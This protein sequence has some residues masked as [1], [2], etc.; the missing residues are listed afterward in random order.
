MKGCGRQINLPFDSEHPEMGLSPMTCGNEI[1][2]K[3][4]VKKQEHSQTSEKEK[5]E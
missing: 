4:C 1:I 5:A 2:C 3:E